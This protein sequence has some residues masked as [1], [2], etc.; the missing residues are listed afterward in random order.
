MV[1]CSF[2]NEVVEGLSPVEAQEMNQHESNFDSIY[3][4]SQVYLF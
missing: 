3:G 2:L 4:K 1:E